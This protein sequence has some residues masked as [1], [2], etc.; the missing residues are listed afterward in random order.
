[1]KPVEGNSDVTMDSVVVATDKQVSSDLAGETIVLSL[2][3]AMYYGIDDV[4][5]R[6]WELLREPRRV[7]EIR[8]AIVREYDVDHNRCSADVLGF[9]L[10]LASHGLIEVRDGSGT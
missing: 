3:N 5:A 8:D 4:A 6:I 10:E 7:T 2:E 9:I 1:M